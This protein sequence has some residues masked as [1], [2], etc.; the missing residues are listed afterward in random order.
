MHQ[1]PVAAK[2]DETSDAIVAYDVLAWMYD[3]H[4][5]RFSVDALGVVERLLLARMPP[6][7]HLLDLCCGTGRV[8]A[9]LL[10]RGYRVT[11]VDGSAGMLV[12]ARLHAPNATL[13]HADVRAF[14]LDERVDGALCLSD[15]LNHLLSIDDLAQALRHVAAALRPGGWLLFDLNTEAKYAQ[16]WTDSFGIV[17]DDHVY[18]VRIAYDAST[19]LARFD[20]TLLRDAGGWQ[21]QDV[22]LWNRCFAEAEVREALAPAGFAD[23]QLFDWRRDLDPNGEPGKVFVLA[24]RTEAAE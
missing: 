20:A 1:S 7:A 22:T 14:T 9:E 18:V 6:G 16:H 3:R 11:G 23:V 24:R 21:R 12:Y 19:K 15:S 13:V 17:E 8:S 2:G 10:R 5:Q 4:W